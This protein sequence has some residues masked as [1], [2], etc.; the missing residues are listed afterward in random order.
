[1]YTPEN[2]AM[3]ENFAFTVDYWDIEID[4][5]IVATA[6]GSSSSTSATTAGSLCQFITR[7][8]NAV[9]CEQLGFAG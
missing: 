2:V 5:A 8:P 4:D 6:G 7:R 1:M 9:G 3:L